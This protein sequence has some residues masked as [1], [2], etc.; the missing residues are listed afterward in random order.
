MPP[1]GQKQNNRMFQTPCY[2]KK[3]KQTECSIHSSRGPCLNFVAPTMYCHPCIWVEWQKD[4][5]CSR[6]N[7]MIEFYAYVLQ[8]KSAIKWMWLC[9]F[10][11]NFYTTSVRTD[12]IKK[13]HIQRL[14]PKFQ[15]VFLSQRVFPF[16]NGFLFYNI[17]FRKISFF[18]KMTN[19]RV[20]AEANFVNNF[21]DNFGV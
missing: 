19:F 6:K 13:K 21:W 1:W 11:K 3:G 10:P 17:F 20:N 8:L 14:T 16:Q 2:L 9:G 4:R 15:N 7:V 5:K 18:F 12:I